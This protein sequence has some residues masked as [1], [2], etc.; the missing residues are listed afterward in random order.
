M[1]ARVLLPTLAGGLLIAL[2]AP[3]LAGDQLIVGFRSGTTHARIASLVQEAGGRLG[4]PLD[5]I[6]AAVVRPRTG[7]DTSGL[8]T[9]LRR[10]HAV[11]YAE[12]DFILGKSVAPDDPSYG[13]QY[14]LGTNANGISA[15]D[16]WNHRTSC[17]LVAAL[18]TGSQYNH[19]DLSSNIWHNSHEKKANNVDD[20]H[21]GYVD[22][23]YGVNIEKGRDSGS[24]GDGHGTH[25]A[26]IMAGH[27]DNA[28][29]ISGVCWKAQVMPIRFMNDK[30]KGSTSDAIAG[31]DYAIHQHA[32]IVNCSFGSSSKS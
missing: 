26:G 4:R 9:R 32:K 27:G 7:S 6:G 21:N 17:S 18:D 5:R 13:L 28:A 15:P 16:A 29:G 8:R 3:A 25:V 20:D 11:R 31:I 22:D 14:A 2:P 12:P 30:G 1:R 23:Y 10:L 19:P 24:D